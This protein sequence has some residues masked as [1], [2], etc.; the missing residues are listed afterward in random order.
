MNLL[1]NIVE[2]YGQVQ[3]DDLIDPLWTD[4]LS[5]VEEAR[6]ALDSGFMH[7]DEERLSLACLPDATESPPKLYCVN[8]APYE[9]KLPPA[10]LPPPP[11]SA[12]NPSS[13]AM[14]AGSDGPHRIS[15]AIAK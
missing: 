1:E 3:W 10:P 15:P 7:P 5:H 14:R 8:A 2:P 4:H 11:A 12:S 6:V 9:Q 13:R